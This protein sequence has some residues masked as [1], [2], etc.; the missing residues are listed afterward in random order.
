MMPLSEADSPRMNPSVTYLRW[1]LERR[2][3]DAPVHGLD[4]GVPG[5]STPRSPST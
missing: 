5:G 1:R 3:I 4:V 2:G